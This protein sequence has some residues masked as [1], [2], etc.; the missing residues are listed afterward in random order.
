MPQGQEIAYSKY[1]TA[2]SDT[3]PI[4]NLYKTVSLQETNSRVNSKIRYKTDINDYWQSARETLKLMTGDCEDYVFLK[5]QYIIQNGL[6][7][8]KDIKV[9][10]V[11]DLKKEIHH[12]L[13]VVGE[14]VLDNQIDKIYKLNSTTFRN[15]Y[16]ML[17]T[18]K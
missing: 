1:S 13:L 2:I 7:K 14:L 18:V 8:E 10:L 9:I 3:K 4:K 12:A 11:Y 6:A 16:K 5:R 17:V 15:R